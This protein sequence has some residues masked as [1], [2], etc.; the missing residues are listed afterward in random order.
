MK[1]AAEKRQG[2]MEWHGRWE[3]G[4]KK[5]EERRFSKR[6]FLILEACALEWALGRQ[7]KVVNEITRAS[8]TTTHIH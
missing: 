1:G 4:D 7:H 8:I 3:E 2:K 6:G 5:Q